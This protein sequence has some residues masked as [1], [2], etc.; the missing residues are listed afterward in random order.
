MEEENGESLESLTEEE[1]KKVLRREEVGTNL[2]K[3]ADKIYK[4]DGFGVL[5]A[6]QK[7]ND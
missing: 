1:L 2:K 6:A 3:I 4:S 7:T 5:D